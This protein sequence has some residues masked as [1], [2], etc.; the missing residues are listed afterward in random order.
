MCLHLWSRISGKKIYRCVIKRKKQ[1]TFIEYILW[2]RHYMMHFPYT[3]SHYPLN[4]HPHTLSHLGLWTWESPRP[5]H[6]SGSLLLPQCHLPLTPLFT[7]MHLPLWDSAWAPVCLGF[8]MARFLSLQ[9]LLCHAWPQTAT[10]TAICFPRSRVSCKRTG[11]M[12]F[13]LQW[14][15]C[16]GSFLPH[17]L[18]GWKTNEWVIEW[19]KCY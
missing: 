9:Y 7:W 5:A 18:P 2:A 17:R 13:S 8:P 3:R 4:S 16:I 14:G 10:M 6:F 15:E 19:A 11:A 1:V 12:A